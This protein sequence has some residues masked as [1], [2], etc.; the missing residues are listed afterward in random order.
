LALAAQTAGLQS[1]SIDVDIVS[2]WSTNAN[3]RYGTLHLRHRWEV[4]DILLISDL[5]DGVMESNEWLCIN[6]NPRGLMKF[7]IDEIELVDLPQRILDRVVQAN[8]VTTLAH[9]LQEQAN[10]MSK[11]RRI[12]FRPTPFWW[13]S[14]Y[15][16]PRMT[17]WEN[18]L[19]RLSHRKKRRHN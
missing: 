15:P 5:L 12:A 10:G 6:R 13:K 1:I 3:N 9:E 7:A 17:W 4:N 2:G 18:L 14:D 19:T 16:L 8:Y 11:E